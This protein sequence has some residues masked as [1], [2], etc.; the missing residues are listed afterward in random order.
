MNVY[1]HL[2]N[3]TYSRTEKT[4]TVI[5]MIMKMVIV[6]IDTTI[7]ISANSFWNMHLFHCCLDQKLAGISFTMLRETT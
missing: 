5:G 6:I 2:E 4:I 7:E 1:S 3:T